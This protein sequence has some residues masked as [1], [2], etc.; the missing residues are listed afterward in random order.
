MKIEQNRTFISYVLLRWTV[1][2]LLNFSIAL[3]EEKSWSYF[4]FFSL[5][6]FGYSLFLGVM[7]YT[8]IHISIDLQKN[9]K[10]IAMTSL[11]VGGITSL[12]GHS[13]GL[14]LEAKNYYFFI[15]IPETFYVTLVLLALLIFLKISNRKNNVL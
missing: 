4:Y 9:F 15:I 1:E 13:R 3:F 14:S 12:V 6:S 11:V 8:L 7:L 5:F 10:L 2:I